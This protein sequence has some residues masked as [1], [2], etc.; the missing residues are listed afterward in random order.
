M[1]VGWGQSG[2]MEWVSIRLRPIIGSFLNVCIHR[3]PRRVDRSPPRVPA[4]R[5]ADPALRQHPD[6]QL[7]DAARPLP[8]LRRA[9]LGA[10]PAGRAADRSP[11]PW[12]CSRSA[13]AH[14]L[15]AF[16]FLAALIVITFIDLDH[17]IIPD[18]ISLPGIGVG[19]PRRSVS[20]HPS[21]KASLGGIVLGGGLL[22]AV[23]EG[24]YPP[25]RPRGH[26]RRRR[27]AARHDRRLPRLARH[28]GDRADRL[29][30]RHDHRP[31]ADAAQPRG[32]TL[33]I[34]FG[35]FLAV[36]ALGYLFIGPEVIAWYIYW[37]KH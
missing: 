29:A 11:R 20:A 31:R 26:G 12:R 28:P 37:M 2:H 25:H 17:Q 8:P 33:A 22:W 7:P 23:A 35:P 5:P 10:L 13:S 15:L 14:A 30:Q 4:L 21:W 24:Y 27:Q 36:G 9:H 3:L 34:P 18:A 32:P 19:W 16:A 6:P 1:F